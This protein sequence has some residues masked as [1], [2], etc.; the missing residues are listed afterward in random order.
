LQVITIQLKDTKATR[1]ILTYILGVAIEE[2]EF[3]ASDTTAP[4]EKAMCA[5]YGLLAK[6][7]DDILAAA[8]R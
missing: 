5:A 3:L 6:Q 8:R 7:L 1:D 4:R 2:Q